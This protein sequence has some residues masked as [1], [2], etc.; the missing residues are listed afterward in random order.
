MVVLPDGREEFPKNRT[1]HAPDPSGNRDRSSL[2]VGARQHQASSGIGVAG[3]G[4]I[5]VL[6]AA[7]R[8]EP[9]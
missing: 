8:N 5:D 9:R 2:R 1:W 7:R 4:R 3:D 6:T